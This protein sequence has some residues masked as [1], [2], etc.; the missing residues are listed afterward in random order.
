MSGAGVPQVGTRAPG[1]TLPDTHGTPV[2]LAQLRGTPVAVVFFPFAFSGICT[3]ELCELRDDIAAFDDAGVRLLA[4]SCDP[5][6]AL[7][8]WSEQERFPFDLLSDFW[9]HGEAARA[10]GVFDEATGHALRGSFLVDADGVLRWSVVNPR[11]QARPLS[12]YRQAL[13]ALSA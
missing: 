8:A 13:A 1:L 9:P 10:Y 3:A 4:V 11:G 7:R 5:M 12:A 6:F 2:A